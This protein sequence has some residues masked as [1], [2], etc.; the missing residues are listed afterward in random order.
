MAAINVQFSYNI[1]IYIYKCIYICTSDVI[2][3]VNW[4]VNDVITGVSDVI[5]GVN[6]VITGV[7]DVITGEQ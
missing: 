2:T 3:G 1:Y 6:D 4:C 7:S 5:T